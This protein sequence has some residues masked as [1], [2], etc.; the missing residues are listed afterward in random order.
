MASIY[1]RASKAR[2]GPEES[3]DSDMTSDDTS[4]S[5][6]TIRGD[7]DLDQ[8]ENLQP[9]TPFSSSP[10]PSN[11]QAE[12]AEARKL[13]QMPTELRNRI[14]MLTSRGV[15]FRHRHLLN[16]LS[17]LLPH[18][19]QDT[20]LD[21]KSS[22]NYNSALNSLADLHSCNYVFFLEARKNA[23]DLYLW[24]AKAPNGPTIKFH[25][26]NVHTM[27]ELGFGGNVLK[28][29]RGITVFDKSFDEE[30]AVGGQENK[31]LIREMLRGV[32]C[33]PSKGVRG[34]KPFVDR[35]VGIY[36]LDGKIWI[37]VYELREGS[38]DSAED[39]LAAMD[40]TTSGVKLVEVG[41]RFVLTPIVIQEGSFGGPVIFEN[42]MYVSPNMVRREARMKKQS[43]YTQRTFDKTDRTRK[44]RGLGLNT[45]AERKRR[46][47][48]DRALFG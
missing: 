29:G 18:S 23:Q 15:S 43:K 11:Q 14:L 34:L 45:G 13:K 5:S 1:K 4:S 27:A 19:Y 38:K 16:D 37:R 9:A 8:V 10:P 36:G 42:K 20:K 24:L 26:G 39:K 25:V 28:G 35:V 44:I 32:F 40:D 7:D 31:A 22:N 41:P 3:D 33:V 17:S 48:D 47:V 30:L 21:T 2:Y 46:V 6:G 12:A